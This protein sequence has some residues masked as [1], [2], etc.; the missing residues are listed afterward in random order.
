VFAGAAYCQGA[1][2][3]GANSGNLYTIASG[4]VVAVAGAFGEPTRDIASDGVSIYGVLSGSKNLGTFPFRR[5]RPGLSR[6]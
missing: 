6:S 5:R 1:P 3:F 4:G 2:Y